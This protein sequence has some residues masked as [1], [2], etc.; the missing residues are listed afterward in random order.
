MLGRSEG[1]ADSPL[2]LLRGDRRLTIS[3]KNVENDN[4]DVMRGALRPPRASCRLPR[5]TSGSLGG[6]L[7]GCNHRGETERRA[8]DAT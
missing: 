5:A 4:V 1:R 3:Q 2:R 6:F 8:G 7:T